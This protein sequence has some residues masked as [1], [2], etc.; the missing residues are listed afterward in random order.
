MTEKNKRI[1]KAKYI[2]PA[3]HVEF[4]NRCSV[5]FW[6]KA[7][8]AGDAGYI[9]YKWLSADETAA[10]DTGRMSSSLVNTITQNVDLGLLLRLEL[11]TT[12]VHPMLHCF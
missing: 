11:A 10:A 6:A 12:H 9:K 2:T 4:C 7:D 1:T 5:T 3:N 8:G